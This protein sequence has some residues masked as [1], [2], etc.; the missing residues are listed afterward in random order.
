MRTGLRAESVVPY[1]EA[2]LTV[3]TAQCYPL[4][5]VNTLQAGP[6]A[7]PH[8]DQRAWHFH[9]QSARKK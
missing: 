1:L 6:E 9:T 3:N 5:S 8:S 7:H 4:S 2:G